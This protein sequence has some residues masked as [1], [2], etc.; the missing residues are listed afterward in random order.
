M[1]QTLVSI[2][3]IVMY[4]YYAQNDCDPLRNGDVENP[5][6]VNPIHSEPCW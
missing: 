2:I 5:N 6:Q 3:G 4:A 1:M